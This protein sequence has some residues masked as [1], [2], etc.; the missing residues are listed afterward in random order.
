MCTRWLKAEQLQDEQA[1]LANP[2]PVYVYIT[3][4]VL[5]HA[6]LMHRSTVIKGPDLKRP[7]NHAI[8]QF[9]VTQAQVAQRC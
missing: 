8:F 3:S 7:S 2:F 9:F 1:L 4:P 5:E 6:A